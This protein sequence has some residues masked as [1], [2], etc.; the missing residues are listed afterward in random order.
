MADLIL[1]VVALAVLV[2]A[3]VVLLR[4][5]R[6]GRARIGF[7]IAVI[8]LATGVFA[9]T[10]YRSQAENTVDAVA[11]PAPTK[12]AVQALGAATFQI[13]VP[14]GHGDMQPQGALY[15]DPP[16]VGTDAYTGDVSL[17]CYTPAKNDNQQNCTGADKRVWTVSPID[18]RATIADADG[19]PFTDPTACDGVA[20]KSDFVELDSG[21]NY[22]LRTKE[23]SAHTVGLRV[24]AFN[25]Q[26]PLPTDI[27]VQVAVLTP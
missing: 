9:V 27:L 18:G 1:A 16:R 21:K 20:Y 22:C 7:A 17:G 3:A 8:V 6:L 24:I 15:L 11:S 19:D 26:V 23:S 5:E 13:D 12:A 25:A 14:M 10:L 2:V 4:A